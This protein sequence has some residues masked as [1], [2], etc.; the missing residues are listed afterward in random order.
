MN[1]GQG[2]TRLPHKSTMTMRIAPMSFI[3][4]FP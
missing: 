4:K 2:R 3:G 1:W